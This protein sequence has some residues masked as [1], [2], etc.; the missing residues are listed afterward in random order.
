MRSMALFRA[1]TRVQLLDL[2]RSPSYVVPTVL[3]PAMFYVLFDLPFARTRAE[4]ANA[5]TRAFVA[6]AVVGV[7]L[8]QFGVGVAQERGRPWERYVRALPVSTAV[9]FSSRIAS[10][11][12][13]AIASAAVVALT[14]LVLTPIDLSPV[15]WA[16]VF[17]AACAAG[18]PFVFMGI[19]IGY[20]TNARAAVP[21]ATAGNLLLAYA[22][23]LWMPPN[24]LPR[25]VA[26]VSPYLPTR[27][28][29]DL[30]WSVAGMSDAPRA[31]AGLAVYAVVFA[32]IA[33][34]GYRQDERRRYA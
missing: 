7:A 10:A 29:A 22:G 25:T 13:F 27:M 5:V 11:L 21:I 4:A 3:F 6:F 14:A 1:H 28:F 9:R 24:D 17:L 23:G 8:Y 19:A 2:A 31:L 26:L 20:W 16:L 15:Q 32:L 12:L 30:L 18:V 34:A 33:A